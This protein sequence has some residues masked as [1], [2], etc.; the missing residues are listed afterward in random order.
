MAHIFS[1]LTP[2]NEL[3]IDWY[4]DADLV[5]RGIKTIDM[6]HTVFEAVQIM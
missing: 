6:L 5:I 4:L 2:S 1:I 3:K